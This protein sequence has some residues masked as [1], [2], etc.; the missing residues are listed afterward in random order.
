[1][2]SFFHQKTQKTRY[3]HFAS[4]IH[5]ESTTLNYICKSNN[6]KECS[7]KSEHTQI[8]DVT[9]GH[10]KM[11]YEKKEKGKNETSLPSKGNTLPQIHPEI[12]AKALP[13]TIM[14]LKHEL[15]SERDLTG[16]MEFLAKMSG[17][18]SHAVEE[19]KKTMGFKK[20]ALAIAII[21][22][23]HCRQIINSPGGYL[24][25]MIA[26]ENRSELYLERSLYALMK[27]NS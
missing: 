5:I 11:A 15:Q 7:E 3:R 27:E 25:G 2:K 14:F 6:K 1:M 17:I 19:A 16:S 9:F 4:K 18:S 8:T 22:E 24:R 10:D 23:K 20:A 21:V 13:N 12:L 26:K